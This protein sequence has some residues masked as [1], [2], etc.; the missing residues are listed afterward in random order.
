MWSWFDHIW[1]RVPRTCPRL[2]ARESLTL[3]LLLSM[4]R[5]HW[6][7]KSGYFFLKNNSGYTPVIKHS[8]GKSPFSI[9]N[10]S[11][12]GPFPI[13]MLDYRSVIGTTQ[14]PLAT[15]AGCVFSRYP[16]WNSQLAPEGNSSSNHPFSGVNSLL[17]SGRV[18]CNW[19]HSQK[20]KDWK[21]KILAAKSRNLLFQMS[22]F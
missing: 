9:G 6:C 14:I 10:T 4:D 5:I 16:P 22:N 20:L 12:K 11:S 15:V 3:L 8:N 1:S 18:N 2:Q 19:I 21:L 17:V 7:V 13:A